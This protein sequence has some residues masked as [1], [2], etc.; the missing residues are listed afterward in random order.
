MEITEEKR[1][2]EEVLKGSETVLFVDDENVI[3]DV[4]YRMLKK[5]GYKVLLA[6]G[7]EKAIEVYKVH[8]DRIDIVIL[9]MIMPNMSGG[10]TYDILKE[11]NPDVKVLLSSGYSINGQATEILG[12]GCSGFIQKPFSMKELSR[13]LRGI[14]DKG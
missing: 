6:K 10:K 9:D 3:I 7:G 8:K 4:G 11:I 13:K 1:L 14:L 5:I 12:R 2:A